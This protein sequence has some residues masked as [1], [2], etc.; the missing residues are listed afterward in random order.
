MA[1]TLE[2]GMGRQGTGDMLTKGAVEAFAAEW[3]RKLDEHVPAAE[4]LAMLDDAEFVLPETSF[5]GND[6]FA[7]WYEGVIAIFFDEIHTL[8]SVDVERRDGRAVAGVVVNWQA[9]RWRAPAPR[10][11]WIGF[12]AF[13]Q[14]EM[15]PS[16]TT[17]APVITRYVVNELRPMPGS[18]AL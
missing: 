1:R 6:A 12:D 2:Q 10:S 18:P 17:G 8:S 5:R 4:L 15:A 11:E 16:P 7:R 14:W 3:Y 9:R 13:Q